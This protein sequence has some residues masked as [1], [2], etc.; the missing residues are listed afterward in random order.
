MNEFKYRPDIDGLR[1]IVMVVLFHAGFG[2]SSGFIGVDVFF[3][4]SGYLITG[5][6]LKHQQTGTFDLKDFWLRRIRRIMPAS[7]LMTIVTLLVAGFYFVPDD[8]ESVAKSALCHQLM[9]G[10]IY[11]WMNSGYFD[12]AMEIQP[13][14]HTWSL[15]VEEQFYLIYPFLL[16]WM[17]K[18]SPRSR[19]RILWGLFV[20]SL[21]VSEFLVRFDSTSAFYL[22]PSRAWEMILGGLLWYLPSFKLNRLVKETLSG[23]ALLTI[24]GCSWFLPQGIAFPGLT[25]AIPCLATAILISTSSASQT[26]TGKLLSSK[27]PVFIGLISYSWY[28]WHWPL[29]VLMKYTYG[30]TLS[31][32]LMAIAVVASA[33]LAVLSWRFVETPFRKKTWIPRTKPLLLS[34]VGTSATIFVMASVIDL[35]EGIPERLTGRAQQLFQSQQQPHYYDGNPEYHKIQKDQVPIRGDRNGDYTIMVWGDSHRMAIMPAVDEICRKKNIKCY[36]LTYPHSAPLLLDE[37]FNES[38]EYDYVSHNQACLDFA[39]RNQ[40]DQIVMIGYWMRYDREMLSGKRE[41][42]LESALQTTLQEV[43]SLGIPVVLLE[44]YPIYEKHI[45][46]I[47]LLSAWKDED[48]SG[49]GMELQRHRE[50]SLR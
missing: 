32:E 41:V 37:W 43:T 31:H 35:Q 48:L 2:F 10:N 23:V 20:V 22:L 9:S 7:M 5:L 29:I 45:E 40:V 14:L 26:A 39:V 18:F 21:V 19:G 25:A 16:W 44:D 42:S 27:V 34:V 13:L 33:L 11:F 17:G 8:Y 28:L 1:A 36:Q 47:M 49:Y 6:I 30:E 50:R 24:V 4:I 46:T 12:P 15:A 38:A 3:V